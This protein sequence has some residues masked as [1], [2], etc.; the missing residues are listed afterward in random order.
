VNTTNQV[1]SIAPSLTH[2]FVLYTG[3]LSGN[4]LRKNMPVKPVNTTRQGKPVT[5]YRWGTSGK[6]YTGPGAKARAAA[7]GRAAFASGYKGKTK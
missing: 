3:V 7:H 4:Q 5:G 6:V 2:Q 1:N